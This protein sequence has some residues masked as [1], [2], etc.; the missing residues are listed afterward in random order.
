MWTEFKKCIPSHFL[1]VCP[2]LPTMTAVAVLP[3]ELDIH[4]QCYKKPRTGS[5]ELLSW[6]G[7][8][9]WLSSLHSCSSSVCQGNPERSILKL[10]VTFHGQ[11]WKSKQM[12]FQLFSERT[13]TSPVWCFIA[14]I[15]NP[16]LRISMLNSKSLIAGVHLDCGLLISAIHSRSSGA[17]CNYKPQQKIDIRVQNMLW[18]DT[19]CIN[20]D[21]KSA[22]KDM[23]WGHWK[24]P[25][26]N[27]FVMY[28]AQIHL[29]CISHIKYFCWQDFKRPHLLPCTISL[30]KKIFFSE[31]RSQG[32]P[33]NN[34]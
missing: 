22:I 32:V 21:F 19:I 29:R 25:R 10:P 20:Q 4:S 33:D 6:S 13:W 34:V 3:A 23:N 17:K 12:K 24:L 1:P 18:F 14:D 5:W 30:R 31:H 28:P 16:F 27:L 7:V 8:R 11:H 2:G 26:K 15:L 9:F